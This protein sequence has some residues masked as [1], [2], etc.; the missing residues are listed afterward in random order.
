MG[1]TFKGFSKAVSLILAMAMVVTCVPTSAY[2]AELLVDGSEE[3]LLEESTPNVESSDVSISEDVNTSDDSSDAIDT[4]EVLLSEGDSGNTEERREIEPDKSYADVSITFSCS[5]D[6]NVKFYAITNTGRVIPYDDILE[7]LYDES[8]E[9]IYSMNSDYSDSFYVVPKTGYELA[10]PAVTVSGEYTRS[11]A[12]GKATAT[13]D[14]LT[15]EPITEPELSLGNREHGF[16]TKGNL[17]IDRYYWA[18]G[19]KV[20]V[21]GGAGSFLSTYAKDKLAAAEGFEDFSEE[22][23]LKITANA[24]VPVTYD[25]PIYTYD[26]ENN[27]LGNAKLNKVSLTYGKAYAE[28]PDTIDIYGALNEKDWKDYYFNVEGEYSPYLAVFAYVDEDDIHAEGLTEELG[29]QVADVKGTELLVRK[30]DKIVYNFSDPETIKKCLFLIDEVNND[31]L[32]VLKENIENK[33][34]ELGIDAKVA[35][36]LEKKS[37]DKTYK[38]TAESTDFVSFFYGDGDKEYDGSQKR[39]DEESTEVK[40]SKNEK[41]SIIAKGTDKGTREIAGISYTIGDGKEVEDTEAPY[42][43]PDGAGDVVIK[44]ITNEQVYFTL[45]NDESKVTIIGETNTTLDNTERTTTTKV[46]SNSTLKFAVAPGV[47]K[48]VKTV[49]YT[50][51]N[52][53]G[54]ATVRDNHP[55]TDVD[56]IYT[57]EDIKGYV[58]VSIET[59]PVDDTINVK[60]KENYGEVADIKDSKT[61]QD[62]TTVAQGF[63]FPN[64]EYSFIVTAKAGYKVDEVT[65]ATEDGKE[66]TVLKGTAKDSY[67]LTAPDKGVVVITVTTSKA[68]NVVKVKN[69]YVKLLVN[70]KELKDGETVQVPFNEALSLEANSANAE[71]MAIWVGSGEEAPIKISDGKSSVVISANEMGRYWTSS[72]VLYVYVETVRDAEEGS[73]VTKFDGK[74]LD[75]IDMYAGGKTSDVTA[76]FTV[77]SGKL[78]HSYSVTNLEDYKLGLSGDDAIAQVVQNESEFTLT[79]LDWKGG[80]EDTVSDTLTVSY[81]TTTETDNDFPNHVRFTDSVPVNV[82]SLKSKGIAVLVSDNDA[83]EEGIIGWNEIR[84]N[85]SDTISLVAGY[86]PTS[87]ETRF[88][89]ASDDIESVEWIVTPPQSSEVYGKEYEREF[90][91]DKNEIIK[92]SKVINKEGFDTLTATARVKFADGTTDEVSATVNIVEGTLDYF[93]IPT[94]TKSVETVSR[95]AST[96]NLELSKNRTTPV[97]SAN[98][99]YSVYHALDR[100]GEYELNNIS[101]YFDRYEYDDTLDLRLKALEDAGCIELID[102]SEVTW[103]FGVADNK[104]EGYVAYSGDKGS[105]TLTAEKRRTRPIYFELN[106]KVGTYPVI[107]VD[108]SATVSLELHS[109]EVALVTQDID[110]ATPVF[111]NDY[112]QNLG[113]RA[114]EYIDQEKKKITSYVLTDVAD[115]A[116]VTLPGVEAFDPATID[117]KRS[118][119]GWKVQVFD[120]ATPKKVYEVYPGYSLYVNPKYIYEVTAVWAP[121]YKQD[122]ENKTIIKAVDYSAYMSPADACLLADNTEVAIG[123]EIPV[124]VGLYPLVVVPEDE[125]YEEFEV[126]SLPVY[127]EELE[128]LSPEEVAKTLTITS[129]DS[130]ASK[131]V[132]TNSGNIY[133]FTNNALTAAKDTQATTKPIDIALSWK[134]DGTVKTEYTTSVS[135]ISIVNAAE[136]TFEMA[137][138]TVEEGQVLKPAF[139]LKRE[140]VEVRLSDPLFKVEPSI[141]VKDDKAFA[142]IEENSIVIRGIAAGATT[143]TIAFVDKAGTEFKKEIPVTVTEATYKIVEKVTP[144]WG[145]GSL[146]KPEVITVGDDYVA[147]LPLKQNNTLELSIDKAA[148]FFGNIKFEVAYEIKDGVVLEEPIAIEEKEDGTWTITPTTFEGDLITVTAIMTSENDGSVIYYES[149]IIVKPYG[150]VEVFGPKNN[151]RMDGAEALYETEAFKAYTGDK[152]EIALED[153]DAYSVIPVN[154]VYD[155]ENDKYEAYK[156][157]ELADYSAEWIAGATLAE[158]FRGWTATYGKATTKK[159]SDEENEVP[160]DVVPKGTAPELAKEDFNA[161]GTVKYY[162]CFESSDITL[163]GGYENTID[164]DDSYTKGAKGNLR[165]DCSEIQP[166]ITPANATAQLKVYADKAGIIDIKDGPFGS[167]YL[168][169]EKGWNGKEMVTVS[170]GEKENNYRLDKFKIGKVAGKTGAVNLFLVANGKVADTIKVYVNGEYEDGGKTYY[171]YRGEKM[172]NYKA[173]VMVKGKEEVHYYGADGGLID[174]GTFKLED[175]SLVLIKD[176]NQVTGKGIHELKDGDKSSFYYLGEDNKVKTGLFNGLETGKDTDKTYYG[177]P[178]TGELAMGKTVKIGEDT[179]YF[180]K[181]GY[182]AKASDAADEYEKVKDA[183]YYVNKDGKVA[184]NGIFKVDGKDR[185]FREDGTIVN[186]NDPDVKDGKIVVGGVAYVISEDGTAK[187]DHTEHKWVIGDF[188]WSYSKEANKPEV[189][190]EFT[191][192]IGGEKV[193]AVVA[194][195]KVETRGEGD[196]QIAKWTASVSKDPEGK[197]FQP[198]TETKYYKADG[199]EATEK[200]WDDLK[201]KPTTGLEIVGLKDEYEYTGTAIKPAFDVVDHD[202]DDAVLVFK[203]D[204]SV[205]YKNNNPKLKDLGADGVTATIEITGKNNYALAD[206]KVPLTATFKIVNPES[207]Y[208][209]ENLATSVKKVDKIAEKFSYDG[210]AKYPAKIGVTADGVVITMEYDEASGMYINNADGGKQVIVSVENNVNKGTANV[211]VSGADGKAK[212]TTFK[213]DAV[214]LS[215]ASAEDLIIEAEE[216]PVYAVSGATAKLNVTYKDMTLVEGRDYT[217]K[218]K[219]LNKKNAGEKAA[220]VTITGK[221]N[222]TKKYPTATPINIA[223]YDLEGEYASVAVAAYAGVAPKSIKVTVFDTAGKAIPAKQYKVTV[224]DDKGGDITASNVKLAENAEITVTVTPAEGGNL[225]GEYT[226]DLTVKAGNLSKAK[227]TVTKGFNKPYTGYGVVLEEE[228]FEK[229][230]TVTLNGTAL[231]YGDDFEVVAYTNN[232]KKGTMTVTIQ[233]AEGSEKCSGV[234]TFKVKI[235]PKNMKLSE[236]F[237]AAVETLLNFFR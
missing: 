90:E 99:N 212:K 4:P 38:I 194:V 86:N 57:I 141:D 197:E 102:A 101:E 159:Y 121:A 96:I 225:V 165:S 36:I 49:K 76:T 224:K 154:F 45:D 55:I 128:V 227:V 203:T 58:Q 189:K 77:G 202:R 52:T 98:V 174:N 135:G 40:T 106:A 21:K 233:G 9:K 198:K 170:A 24:A 173:T 132:T 228:D 143:A 56:G 131:F 138:V 171:M 2:A 160:I 32:Y 204:Y 92:I 155:K 47:K 186:Y 27:T 152:K 84:N 146:V 133:T 231:K 44:G 156:L 62:I 164:L 161:D 153:K 192:E 207:K 150:L 191:C 108:V 1:K 182:Q 87:K 144:D 209:K 118:L 127:Q 28:A 119:A 206:K 200:E 23:P 78:T 68:V 29:V 54:T 100:D 8:T 199:T 64:T 117:P 42:I 234:K 140:G 35:I 136:W 6:S 126:G 37:V 11:K 10:S 53:A 223:N 93:A 73:F 157:N 125:V 213:I 120:G 88:I 178:E 34:K 226:K 179:F 67:V 236:N 63:A 50:E 158:Q 237:G 109:N 70:G 145:S 147:E 218:Y 94:I 17:S 208:D 166:R 66:I 71:V 195:E 214:D 123:T 232:V 103:D 115:Y 107:A 31:K 39:T 219:Y 12:A 59:E 139:T 65:A 89:D 230:I 235:A 111:S 7:M 205:K 142:E 168:D 176:R 83:A 193:D 180:D 220:E 196:K 201:P 30:I 137:P 181:S 221:N 51:W 16:S 74:A 172:T 19:V 129:T 122:A 185:L 211:Y 148:S 190:A 85:E 46:R 124:T 149:V 60:T 162:A 210:T 41:F 15:I 110:F 79:T 91:G 97:N 13:N 188:A 177:D 95:Y 80:S 18:G 183:D 187:A 105:Y 169:L 184:N 217:V 81:T 82:S 222:F 43:V 25:V 48:S 69:E 22:N 20:T 151:Q 113:F 130:E 61:R 14:I 134:E 163:A 167:P 175:G 114:E 116:F 33:L 72:K 104:D 112:I 216:D 229:S 75:S 5:A 3:I 215:K 26:K